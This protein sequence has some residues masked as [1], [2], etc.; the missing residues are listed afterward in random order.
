MFVLG[1]V[2]IGVGRALDMGLLVYMWVLIA[3]A[4][5]S[6]VNAD[7][8]NTIVRFLSAATDPV[9][10]RVRRLLPMRVRYFPV[11]IAFLVLFGIIIF[12]RYALAIS[13]IEVGARMKGVPLA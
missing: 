13:L 1:N 9:V 11:D 12:L 4:V 2:L 5:V 3:R 6:W 8:R 10:E 7:P